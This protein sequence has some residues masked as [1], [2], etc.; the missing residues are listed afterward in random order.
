ML[1]LPLVY[2]MKTIGSHLKT[3]QMFRRLRYNSIKDRSNTNKTTL[4]CSKKATSPIECNISNV[5]YEILPFTKI[6]PSYSKPKQ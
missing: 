2:N 3:D 6:S 1:E 5:A 4:V